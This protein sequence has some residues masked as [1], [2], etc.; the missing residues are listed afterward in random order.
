MQR[1]TFK[2]PEET[3]GAVDDEADEEDVSRSEYL[4]MIVDSRHEADRLRS[5]VEDLRDEYEGKLAEARN[6]ATAANR[7]NEQ[8]E[9]LANYVERERSMQTKREI[10]DDKRS[11]AGVLTRASWWLTGGPKVSDEEMDEHL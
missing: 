7:E 10:R 6:R 11:E 1:V 3:L 9:E 4:R 8:V 2:I 5:E